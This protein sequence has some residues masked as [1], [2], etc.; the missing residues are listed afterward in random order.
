MIIMKIFLPFKPLF[1]LLTLALISAGALAEE[2]SSGA[3]HVIGGADTSMLMD[4]PTPRG[5]HVRRGLVGHTT[6]KDPLLPALA[7]AAPGRGRKKKTQKTKRQ[8]AQT[9]RM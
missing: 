1:V 2:D 5:H 7:A 3:N 4:I 9:R 6:T 8:E